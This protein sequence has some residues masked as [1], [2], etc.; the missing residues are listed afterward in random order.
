MTKPWGVRGEVK[1][2]PL[3]DFPERFAELSRVFLVAPKGKEIPCPVQ[4]VRRIGKSLVLLLAGYDSPEAAAAISGW[5]VAVPEEEAVP[6]PEGAYYHFE[7]VGMEVYAE[8]GEHLGRIT[9]VFT[10]PA[11]DVYVMRRGKN[12]VYLPATKE[13]I[14]QVDRAAK[15]MTIHV[16][17]GLL[18]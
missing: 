17:D 16:M 5:L 15:R 11:N 13:I 14:R 18:D 10:T 4:S 9:D 3:T 2:E 12:E 6:L 8:S 1:V 7:L